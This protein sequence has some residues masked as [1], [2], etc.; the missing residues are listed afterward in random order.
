MEPLRRLCYKMK[1]HEYAEGRESNLNGCGE[2]TMWAHSA[3]QK[4][5]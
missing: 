2:G 1:G 5:R 4:K 3:F